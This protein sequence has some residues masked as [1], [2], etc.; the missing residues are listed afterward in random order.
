MTLITRMREAVQQIVKSF[1][2]I[3]TIT[4]TEKERTRLIAQCFDLPEAD[5]TAAV[6][7]ISNSTTLSREEALNRVQQ[8]IARHGDNW[9]QAAGGAT[10]LTSVR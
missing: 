10:R 9:R 7:Q 1:S 2:G 6:D 8:T 3:G 4:R 5:I